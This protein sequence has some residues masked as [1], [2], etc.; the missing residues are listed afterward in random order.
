VSQDTN[1][2]QMNRERL[3]TNSTLR[4]SEI[5]LLTDDEKENTTLLSLVQR[6]TEESDRA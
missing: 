5:L 3:I 2:Y 4:V 6:K 1:L